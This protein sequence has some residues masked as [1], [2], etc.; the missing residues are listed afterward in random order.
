A[1]H[2]R[3]DARPR[4][5]PSAPT[6]RASDLGDTTAAY[7]FRLL[8]LA[9][10][11]PITPGTVVSGTLEPGNETDVYRFEAAAGDRV[12]FDLQARSGAGGGT[13]TVLDPIDFRVSK[14]FFAVER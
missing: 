11:A 9:A 2:Q 10:A 1:A 6:R 3:G 8:D 13:R 7:S 5:P 14:A 12:F 4:A